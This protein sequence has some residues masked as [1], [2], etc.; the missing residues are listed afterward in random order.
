MKLYLPGFLLL[1]L[2]IGTPTWGQTEES[3]PPTR[4]AIL[5]LLDDMRQGAL[6]VRIPTNAKKI[7]A[8]QATIDR[9]NLSEAQRE[10]LT[11]Q[12]ESVQEETEKFYQDVRA[13]FLTFYSWSEIYFI[14]DYAVAEYLKGETEGQFLNEQ[15]QQDST[16][17]LEENQHWFAVV[18]NPT[19]PTGSIYKSIIIKDQNWETLNPPFPHTKENLGTKIRIVFTLADEVGEWAPVVNKLQERIEKIYT[20]YQEKYTELKDTP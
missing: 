15:M 1:C 11:E 7:S 3:V 4:P 5:E 16:I 2:F 20:K 12:L 9:P 18:S 17:V 14:P 10:R 6:I 8:I 19:D 13:S